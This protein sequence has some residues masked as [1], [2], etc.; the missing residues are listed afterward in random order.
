MKGTMGTM[1]TFGVSVEMVRGQQ[2]DEIEI[3]R[4]ER[5]MERSAKR[6]ASKFSFLVSLDVLDGLLNLVDGASAEEVEK[7]PLFEAVVELKY[8]LENPPWEARWEAGTTEM[9]V[10]I[11][12]EEEEGDFAAEQIVANCVPG[13]YEWGCHEGDGSVGCMMEHMVELYK[14]Q[15]IELERLSRIVGRLTQS[16]DSTGDEDERNVMGMTNRMASLKRVL[17]RRQSVESQALSAGLKRKRARGLAVPDAGRGR[18]AAMAARRGQTVEQYAE[19][20]RVLRAWVFEH[21]DDP[22]P[23]R[24]EKEELMRETGL[25]RMQLDNWFINAR[26]RL[27]PRLQ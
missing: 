20:Q 7:H 24:E 27:V 5:K 23:T 16:L 26:R 19:T 8:G 2:V 10:V 13:N 4:K 22:Y 1:G 25:E 11:V 15:L 18:S 9:E 21:S 17:K 3:E 6:G 14:A 12:E